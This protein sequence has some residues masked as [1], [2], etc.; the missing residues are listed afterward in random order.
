M[1]EQRLPRKSAIQAREMGSVNILDES[2]SIMERYN[3]TYSDNEVTNMTKNRWKK[4][5]EKKPAEAVNKEISAKCT[6]KKKVQQLKQESGSLKG[7]FKELTWEAART[8]F[9]V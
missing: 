4:I 2:R 7:Y 9:K 3:L 6:E 5:I 8:V 1:E